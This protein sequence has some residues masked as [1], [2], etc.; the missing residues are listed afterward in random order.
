MNEVNHALWEGLITT[1]LKVFVNDLRIGIG[2]RIQRA[3]GNVFR[4]ISG[5]SMSAYITAD[6]NNMDIP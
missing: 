4:T 6:A 5:V 1:K 2:V 3:N